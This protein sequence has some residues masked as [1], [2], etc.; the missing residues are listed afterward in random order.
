[1]GFVQIA[2]AHGCFRDTKPTAHA[3]IAMSESYRSGPRLCR[4][5]LVTSYLAGPDGR[6]T[7][8]IPS[9]CPAGGRTGNEPCSIRIDHHRIRKAGPEHPLAVAR[10]R[11]HACGFTLY[12]HG[13][14]PYRRQ[15]VL[16]ITPDGGPM[17]TEEVGL[18][19]DF[20]DTVFA[21]ALD[22]ASGRPWA[23]DCHDSM[24]E[25]FWGTQ[26]RHLRLSARLLGIAQDLGNRVREAVAAVLSIGGLMQRERSS[27]KGF[28]AMGKA[29]CDM[30]R[31]LRGRSASKAFSI[32]VSGHLAGLWGEP[33]LWDIG[34]QDLIRSPFCSPGTASAP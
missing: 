30:L 10:C 17:D 9:C 7:A 18:D 12:P 20:A 5:F 2:V 27:A 1:M 32:L 33:C 31:R 11:T 26:G 16:K 23:R 15:P 24:P 22:A 13:F 28:R 34:R 14:A 4:P 25:R 3:G 29:V 21:A 19:Q 6:W 8:A